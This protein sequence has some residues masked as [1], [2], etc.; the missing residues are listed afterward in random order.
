MIGFF[1]VAFDAKMSPEKLWKEEKKPA[2]T[3]RA[4]E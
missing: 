3:T 1:D 4:G 2:A